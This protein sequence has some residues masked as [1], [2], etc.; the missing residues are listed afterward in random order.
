LIAP[1][2][3]AV[4]RGLLIV[5]F[6]TALAGCARAERT[7]SYPITG[8]V[9]AVHPERQQI[10]LKH[11]DILNFMPSMTMSFPVASADLLKGREPG[12]I[13]TGV[14]EVT[15]A[16]GRLTALERTGFSPL[17]ADSNAVAM[18]GNLLDIGE[19][20][21]DAALI[22]QDDRRR[23]FAEWR[24]TLT[25]LTFIYTRCPLPNFCPLMD[26]HFAALQR[27]IAADPRLAG[28]VRLVSVSFDPE[29]DTPKVL[30]AHAARLNVDPAVWTF[31]TGDRVTIDRF[32]AR[33]GVGLVRPVDA[34][35]ITH[36]LRTML[37]DQDGRLV[38]VYSGSEWTPA[39]ALAD[40]RAAVKA[41]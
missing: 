19:V 21:P 2:T 3:A 41:P 5:A 9:L 6:T 40:L 17:P 25:L 8:Q 35:E 11:E 34:T 32:A 14:L 4:A 1:A 15:D 39:G 23:S 27:E 10:T 24:G 22:D 36:N 13:V 28:K 31:L 29:H 26:R 30:A 12:E 20:A 33:F 16:V 38:K 18:A 7:K 37:L